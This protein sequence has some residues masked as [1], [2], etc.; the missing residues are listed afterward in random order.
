MGAFVAIELFLQGIVDLV[1]C[2][3]FHPV[4]GIKNDWILPNVSWLE[5]SL[6]LAKREGFSLRGLRYC[7]SCIT[8]LKFSTC[9][10]K[11]VLIVRDFK[12]S[13]FMDL[14][15]KSFFQHIFKGFSCIVAVVVVTSLQFNELITNRQCKCFECKLF[16]FAKADRELII[17]DIHHFEVCIFNHGLE[18]VRCP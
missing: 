4:P 10:Y 7:A 11:L 16:R 9:D 5:R 3:R 14:Y 6:H 2:R 18:L 13:I 1:G 15:H 8:L 12:L 17:R